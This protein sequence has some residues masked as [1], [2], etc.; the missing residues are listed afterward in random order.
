MSRAH[1]AH[2]ARARPADPVA[3]A[4]RKR[5]GVTRRGDPD[6]VGLCVFMLVA[7]VGAICLAHLLG[8]LP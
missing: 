7:T 3:P 6:A 2:I 8:Y 5:S 4:E 1:G